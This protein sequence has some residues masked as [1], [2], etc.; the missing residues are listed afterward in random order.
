MGRDIFIYPNVGIIHLRR[1]GLLM[2][3]R[4]AVT[5]GMGASWAGHMAIGRLMPSE[6]SDGIK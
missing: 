5:N 1:H 4:N 2:N 3:G 6:A